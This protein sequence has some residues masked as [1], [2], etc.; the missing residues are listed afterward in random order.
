MNL[1]VLAS[2]TFNS[3]GNSQD[4]KQLYEEAKK[5]VAVFISHVDRELSK[6]LMEH[7]KEKD[8]LRREN[9]LLKEQLKLHTQSFMSTKGWHIEQH[10]KE[11]RNTSTTKFYSQDKIR[12]I[13]DCG[14]SEIS[15]VDNKSI[16][17]DKRRGNRSGSILTDR[18]LNTVITEHDIKEKNPH[19]RSKISLRNDSQSRESLWDEGFNDLSELK[20]RLAN[21]KRSKR[22]ANLVKKDDKENIADVLKNIRERANSSI[23]ISMIS[24]EE[25][26]KEMLKPIISPELFANR[27]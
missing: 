2:K 26:E 16:I 17:S 24:N 1:S 3:S 4:Y 14:I 25:K 27:R 23:N 11:H 7:Q 20:T 13:L 10:P 12:D 15:M 9:G 22:A 21:C 18:C 19:N 5:N 6:I 8:E